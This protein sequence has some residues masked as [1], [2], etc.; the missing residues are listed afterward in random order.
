MAIVKKQ[1]KHNVTRYF[2]IRR[3]EL[4]VKR[5]FRADVIFKYMLKYGICSPYHK[6][7]KYS[8]NRKKVLDCVT[9]LW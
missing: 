7:G 5:M 4:R 6:T 9:V 1:Q 8:L 2:I 3:F